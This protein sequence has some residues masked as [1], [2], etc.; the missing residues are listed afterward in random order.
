MIT[1]NDDDM[2]LA[3]SV[4]KLTASRASGMR[5]ADGC[6]LWGSNTCLAVMGGIH[7]VQ[8]WRSNLCAPYASR[9]VLLN[10]WLCLM[11]LV[12]MPLAEETNSELV[13][14]L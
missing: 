2:L 11:C 9:R 7:G 12:V 8:D 6:K 14:K 3:P 4:D 1:Q 5:T 13:I 10:T